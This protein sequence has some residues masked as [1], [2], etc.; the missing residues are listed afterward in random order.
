MFTEEDAKLT[1]NNSADAA[2][3]ND[4]FHKIAEEYLILNIDIMAENKTNNI[5]CMCKARFTRM[6]SSKRNDVVDKLKKEDI[7]LIKTQFAI[8]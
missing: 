4:N 5:I 3:T 7:D 1:L 2:I 6:D 8:S